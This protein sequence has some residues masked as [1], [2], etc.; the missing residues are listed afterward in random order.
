MKEIDGSI[1]YCSNLVDFLNKDIVYGKKSMLYTEE[2][3]STHQSDREIKLKL[4]NFKSKSIQEA[5]KSILEKHEL[6]KYKQHKDILRTINRNN[7][8]INIPANLKLNGIAEDFNTQYNFNEEYPTQK[9]D[10]N[11]RYI[12]ST[13]IESDDINDDVISPLE[14]VKQFNVINYLIQYT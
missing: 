13:K 5:P 8:D 11:E 12:N 6:T 3:Y 10:N 4:K 1:E 7:L 14:F 9:F 2:R